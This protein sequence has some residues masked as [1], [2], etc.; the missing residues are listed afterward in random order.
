MAYPDYDDTKPATSTQTV[1]QCATSIRNNLNAIR[2]MLVMGAA[3]G[4]NM[5]V[6]TGTGTA[7][8]PE[9]IDWTDQTVV[10]RGTNT[11]L[12][13]NVTSIAYVLNPAGSNDSIGTLNFT[14][15]ASGNVTGSTWT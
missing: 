6:N 5:T 15:D 9:Y 14:Y 2:D 12:N 11:W 8:E 3:H 7:E 13:N 10:I 4:W 1:P